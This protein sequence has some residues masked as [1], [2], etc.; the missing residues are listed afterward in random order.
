MCFTIFL[1]EKNAFLHYKN[2]KV[3]KVEKLGF[4]A[5]GLVFG[6]GEKLAIFSSFYFRQNRP[7]KF[8]SL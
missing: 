7:E 1:K 2:K 4:F 8:V 3:E 5:K 6:S